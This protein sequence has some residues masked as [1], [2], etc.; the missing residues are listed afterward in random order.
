MH[1]E[2]FAI[3]WPP[4]APVRVLRNSVTQAQ[5]DPASTP[6]RPEPIAMDD[7]RSILRT[8]TDSPLRTTTGDLEALAL[9]AGQ[10]AGQLEAIPSVQQRI[11]AIVVAAEHTLDALQRD[12]RLS[13]ERSG[14]LNE[15]DET[16]TYA[17]SPCYL[18]EFEQ[19][20]TKGD[21]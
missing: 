19:D 18:H 20:L 9:Y 3:N 7:G 12:N 13:T 14:E 17:S 15:A 21:P 11:D 4:H 8:S 16:G 1:T 5:E 10:V 2:V 6:P